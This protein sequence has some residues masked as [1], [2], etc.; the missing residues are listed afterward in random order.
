MYHENKVRIKR[1][2][3]EAKSF[4]KNVFI[5]E[6]ITRSGLWTVNMKHEKEIGPTY[7]NEVRTS[8]FF[9]FGP[10]DDVLKT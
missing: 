3:S 2:F 9:S 6:E 4:Q 7:H 5:R 8:Y 10:E 1:I